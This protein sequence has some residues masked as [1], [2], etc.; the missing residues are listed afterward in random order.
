MA[1]DKKPASGP[2]AIA[3]LKA[4]HEAVKKLFKQFS[5]LCKEDGRSVEKSETVNQICQELTVHATIEEE[6]FYPALREALEEQDLLDEAEVEHATAKDLIAQIQQAAPGDE[7]FD[8]RVIVLGEYIEHHVKEEEGEMFRQARKAGVDMKE[9]GA[10]L[11]DRQT[12]LKGEMGLDEEE[13]EPGPG[14][15]RKSDSAGNGKR[16][17]A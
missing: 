9:L 3:L 6:I 11:Q 16:R 15:A 12:Q 8:A 10:Q 14:K 7:L 1:T 4:D 2:D 17:A 13:D 5:K